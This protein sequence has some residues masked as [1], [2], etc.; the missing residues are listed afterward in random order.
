MVCK[1]VMTELEQND[2]GLK[3]ASK[4]I[5]PSTLND[6]SVPDIGRQHYSNLL[7]G[8]CRLKSS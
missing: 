1:K 6:A 3:K 2:F 8:D 5:V 7:S 4:S